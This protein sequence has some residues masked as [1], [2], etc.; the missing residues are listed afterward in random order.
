MLFSN[1]HNLS[2]LTFN[3]YHL[4]LT[5]NS[6]NHFHLSRGSLKLPK[7]FPNYL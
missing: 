2:I 6:F 4:V 3:K 1:F 5:H 7:T